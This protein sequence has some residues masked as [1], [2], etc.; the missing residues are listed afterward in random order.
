MKK[1]KKL[2]LL[3]LSTLFCFTLSAAVACGDNQ[4]FT[5]GDSSSS[6]SSSTSDEEEFIDENAEY[7]YRVSVENAGGNF[8]FSGVT[9]TLKD[10]DTVVAEETTKRVQKTNSAGETVYTQNAYAIFGSEDITELGEYTIEVSGYPEGYHLENN[11]TTQTLAREGWNGIVTITPSG[12]LSGNAPN[13]TLYEIGEIVHDFS[14]TLPD[15]STWTLS[16]QFK[17]VEDGGE[18][19][20]LVLLNFWATWCNPCKM[21]FPAMNNASISYQDN[22]SVLALSTTDGNDAVADFK[23]EQNLTFTMAGGTNIPGFFGVSGIPHSVMID[24]YGAVVFNHVGSMTATNDFTSRF[25]LFVGEEYVPTVIYGTGAYA[26]GGEEEDSNDRIEP[27]VENPAIEDVKNAFAGASSPFNFRWDAND[28]YAWPWLISDDGEYIYAS[29]ANIHNS[30]SILYTNFTASEGD[31][32]CFDYK[33][34]SEDGSDALYLTLDGVASTIVNLSGNHSSAW[35]TCY[36]YVFKDYEAG[37]QELAFTFLKD[38]DTT[39]YEDVV[40][41]KNLR[42]ENVDNIKDDPNVNANIFRYAATNP[43]DPASEAYKTSQFAEY[44][45]PVYNEEDRYYHVGTA[46][47][48]ILFANMTLTSQWH[49]ETSAWLLAYDGYCFYDGMNYKND[50]EN[51]A[52]EAV[53]TLT[54]NGYAPVTERLRYI[55]ELMTEN[56]NAGKAWRWTD[57]DEIVYGPNHENEWLELCIYF[58]HY[59]ATPQYP[60]PMKGLTYNAAIEVFAGQDNLVEVPR[61]LNPRGFKYKFTADRSG[62]YK[63]YTTGSA[64]PVLFLARHNL[65]T[66]ETNILGS[67]DNRIIAE[68]DPETGLV[69]GNLEFYWYFEEGETYYFLCTTYLDQTATYNLRVEWIDETYT[70]LENAATGPYSTNLI[71]NK[72]YL[73]NAIAYEYADPTKTYTYAETGL[74]AAGDGYY[75][76]KNTDGTLGSIIYLDVKRPTAFFLSDA[77]YETILRFYDE[78]TGEYTV[79]PEKRPFYLDGVDYTERLHV[80]CINAMLKSGDLNGFIEVDQELFEILQGITK[81]TYY[82]GIENDWLRLCYY[83][84][85]LGKDAPSAN[86]NA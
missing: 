5:S 79:P 13:G 27:T 71:T 57:G 42:M 74:Q 81:S 78:D 46:D 17:P 9:V 82:E 65:D 58:E 67:W 37:E 54:L 2:A 66:Y 61:Q 73:P 48:P 33:I 53:N 63:V 76:A 45:T 84:K 28:P 50:F 41:I 29:N 30:Y 77:L 35:Q 80:Y 34:G 85:V 8:G 72:L 86:P 3:V 22:V 4:S 18:G 11:T 15:N 6:S 1:I 75:H 64:D 83:Y 32:I 69:D 55:L 56:V 39:A 51:F 49:H 20:D 14:V 38:G 60:D 47:G 10:G 26:V 52:W 43:N 7:V 21:E 16:D 62:V 31:V 70:Y 44:I 59:G 36:A 40:Y 23:R 24:R 12:I 25:D 68:V 19:K